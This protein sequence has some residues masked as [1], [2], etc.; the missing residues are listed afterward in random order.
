MSWPDCDARRALDVV[1]GKWVLSVL[2]ELADG[3]RR[4]TELQ[5]RLSAVSG[6][7]LTRTPRRMKRDASSRMRWLT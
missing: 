4:Y 1:A 5:A 6:S 7:M 2:A 3:P